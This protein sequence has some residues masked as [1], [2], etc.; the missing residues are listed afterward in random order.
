MMPNFKVLVPIF[1]IVVISIPTWFFLQQDVKETANEQGY[2]L[3][4]LR[5]DVSECVVK[6]GK[7]CWAE[8]K[9]KMWLDTLNHIESVPEESLARFRTGH[10]DWGVFDLITPTY[11]C[12]PNQFSRVGGD[13]DGGKWVCG[14]LVV[15]DT[16]VIF[17]LGSNNQFDFEQ[18]I[19][20][21][22]Q[23]K[24]KIFTFD[25]TGNW[26]DPSTTFYPWCLASSDFVKDG[27]T[28]KRLGNIMKELNVAKISYLKMDIEGYEWQVFDELLDDSVR[29]IS[30]QQ[31]SF[32]LHVA[33]STALIADLGNN[34]NWV[35][36]VVKLARRI[37]AAGYYFA[38]AEKNTLCGTCSEYVIVKKNRT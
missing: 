9:Q 30:P 20:T 6:G 35:Y 7:N 15:D 3:K 22:T 17:S 31:I 26:S 38:V 10:D 11:D 24:C 19:K 21:H 25:C 13:G 27:R 29:S 16:C 33:D 37:D 23:G 8:F 4:M 32:E 5:D 14:P 2:Y 18:A 28:Y 34:A 1:L 12:D 36:P